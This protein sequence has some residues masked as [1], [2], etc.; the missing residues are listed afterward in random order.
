[1]SKWKNGSKSWG[2]SF[3]GGDFYRKKPWL[4]LRKK[5]IE[6]NPLCELCHQYDIVSAGAVV[7]HIVSRRIT[8]DWE[9]DVENLQTLCDDCHNKK[10]AQEHRI[11]DLDS[12]I[13]EMKNGKLQYITTE[14]KKEVILK[15]KRGN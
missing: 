9:L 7:D 13:K 1:M 6:D 14:E 3:D 8:Q 12:Y 4:Q 5:Y 15:K 10:T 11:N 2:S